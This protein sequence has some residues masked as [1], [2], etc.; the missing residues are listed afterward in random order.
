MM[1]PLALPKD[2]AN[3]LHEEGGKVDR[4]AVASAPGL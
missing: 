1:G 3:T 4:H 2:H